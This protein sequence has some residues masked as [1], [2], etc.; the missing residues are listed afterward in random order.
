MIV[1]LVS[2][3]SKNVYQGELMTMKSKLMLDL[4]IY[5]IAPIIL[6]NV[7]GDEYLMYSIATLIAI[8]SMYSMSVKKNEARVNLSGL[9]FVYIY[10]LL[11]ILKKDIVSDYQIYIYDTYFIMLCG[12][13]IVFLNLIDKNIITRIYFDVQRSKG[14]NHLLIWSNI[15]KCELLTEFNKLS[16]TLSLHLILSSLVKVYSI[17]LYKKGAYTLTHD[18]E[19]LISI[20]FL[21]GEIYIVSNI[22][23]KIKLV[24]NK[25]INKNKSK[26]QLNNN[27][28]INFNQYKDANK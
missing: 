12:V 21:I 28:V 8:V 20:I 1:N 18:L 10:I 27:R 16:Y 25:K 4:S 7:F 19:V 13:G 22:M 24:K 15:N 26:Y 6:C 5:M 11:I 9:V 17:L 2:R 14:I 23:S 3:V